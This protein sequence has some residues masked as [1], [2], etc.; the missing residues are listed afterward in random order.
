M[1]SLSPA[2][3]ARTAL[4]CLLPLMLL[5]ACS[6]VRVAPSAGGP[7]DAELLPPVRTDRA[8]TSQFPAADSDGYRPPAQLAV[9]LP[10]TGSAAAAATSVRD[11]FLAA[12]YAETRRRP[13]LKFY[14]SLGSADGALAAMQRA[15]AEGAQMI[16]GPLT[17][18]E[19]A[20]VVAAADG[21]I[22]VIAL[23][24]A[25]RVPLGTT[26]FALVPEAEGRALAERLLARGLRSALAFGNGSDNATRA[27]AAFKERFAMQGGVLVEQIPVLGETADLTERLSTLQA[28]ATPPQAVVLA[29]EAGPARAIAAQLRSSALASLP[30]FATSLIVNG[31]NAR[32]DIELDGIQYPELPWLL[33][34]PVGLPEADA[35]GRNLASARGPAQRLFAFGADAWRLSAW[36]DHLYSQ[37]GASIRGATGDLRIDISGPVEW[38]PAWAVFSG[39]R[40]R[41]APAAVAA[42]QAPGA[43]Q[44]AR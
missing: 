16:V 9:V 3:L 21:S 43:S 22:P 1:Q 33:D 8:S 32:A 26:S 18:P 24:R 20:A 36:F 14:D 19:A 31:A 25:D 27:I 11:G 38:T 7:R 4:A 17:R 12:Y 23:N 13:R 15:R 44:P 40:G 37:P 5:A 6:S 30:R 28:G 10:M 42:P 34:L 41:P 35:L 2:R 39:G 29:L